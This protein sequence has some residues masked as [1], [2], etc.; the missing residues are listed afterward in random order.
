MSDRR[1][2]IFANGKRLNL[3]AVRQ[4]IRPEDYL[5]A[6][7][8]G[9]RYLAQLGL[10]ANLVIGDLDSISS[11]ELAELQKSTARVMRYP[12]GKNET[13]LEL[14]LETVVQEGCKTILVLAAL[15]GRLDMTLSNIF[16]LALPGLAAVD[17]RLEDG[18]EE[19]FLIRPGGTG[20]EISGQP[21][22]T[23][24]L[25]P[26]GGPAGGVRTQ[27]LLYP[28]RGETLYPE[29]SRGISNQLVGSQASVTLADGLL[30]CIHAHEVEESRTQEEE[31]E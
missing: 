12:R 4:M 24:S 25:L 20:R 7:D 1:A 26:W 8:G 10:S 11:A 22:D 9:L 14:A 2:F 15:G 6:A 18:F 30:I 3:A 23:V 21:G 19:V 17:V 31:K 16:L 27:G 5:V 29:R 28:L 13:D